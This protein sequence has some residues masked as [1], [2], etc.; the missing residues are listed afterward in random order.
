MFA[1]C[2]GWG[3]NEAVRDRDSAVNE[4]E[5]GVGGAE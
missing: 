1:E 3:R 2:A 4:V 5:V